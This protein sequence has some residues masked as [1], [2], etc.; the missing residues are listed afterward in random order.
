MGVVGGR[1]RKGEGWTKVLRSR[2]DADK[3][4]VIYANAGLF[5]SV[6]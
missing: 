2:Q 1:C 3:A 5:G 6:P 4:T